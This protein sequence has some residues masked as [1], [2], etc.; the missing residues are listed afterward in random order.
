MSNRTSTVM[1]TEA[2]M[3]LPICALVR[4]RSSR[5]TAISGAMPNQPKKQRKNDIQVMWK[6]RIG[7]VARLNSWM[8]VALLETSMVKPVYG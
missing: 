4:S 7:A 8:R 5:T 6:A 2:M 3:V 1:A